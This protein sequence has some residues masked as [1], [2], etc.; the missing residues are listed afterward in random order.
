MAAIRTAVAHQCSAI[1]ELDVIPYPLGL[2]LTAVQKPVFELVYD[3]IA[4]AV[5]SNEEWIAPRARAPNVE[6]FGRR[7]VCL[8]VREYGSAHA[9]TTTDKTNT[10]RAIRNGALLLMK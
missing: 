7:F 8:E 5:V 3:V 6:I 1:E 2:G 4:C 9:S 10:A